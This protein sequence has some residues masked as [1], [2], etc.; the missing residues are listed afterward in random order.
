MERRHLLAGLAASAIYAGRGEAATPQ[1]AYLEA[2]VWRLHNTTENQSARVADYLE[3]GLGPAL[4]RAGG[5][6]AG[7]FANVI[8]QDGPYYFTV[9]E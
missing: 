5:R 2:K 7:A 3:H 1:A 9:A 4:T 6:L 8:G